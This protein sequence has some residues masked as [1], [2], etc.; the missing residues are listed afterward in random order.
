MDALL[1]ALA[2]GDI[3]LHF[4]NTDPRWKNADS[5][6]MLARVGAL[7]DEKG[8]VIANVDVMVMAEEPRLAPHIPLMRE[9]LSK[10]LG[11]ELGQ[12]SVKA[13][14]HEGLGALG[15]GEG[16]GALATAALFRKTNNK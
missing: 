9:R 12:V 15:R 3:G 10:A 13:G 2:E 7:A 16:I 1:G 5:L 14:T 4:P 8:Y 6:S 11:I